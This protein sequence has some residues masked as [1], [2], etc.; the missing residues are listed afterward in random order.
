MIQPL[1]NCDE[2]MNRIFQIPVLQASQ[3]NEYAR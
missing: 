1:L 3:T 2:V